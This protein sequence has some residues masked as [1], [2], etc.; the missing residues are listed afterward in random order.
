MKGGIEKRLLIHAGEGGNV[1][2]FLLFFMLVSAGMAIGRSSADALFLKRLGIEYLPIMYMVQSLML[3]A[4]SLVYTAF[5]DRIPAER[6][7]RSLFGILI[8]MILGS[9]FVI[10]TSASTLVYPAYYLIYEVSSELL[11]VHATLYLN[12]N[13]TTL[14]AKRLAPLVFAGAQTGTIMGG[15]TLVVAA[16]VIGTAN[17]LLVWCCLLLAGSVTLYVRHQRHGTSTHFR[18]PGKSQHLLQE[19]LVQPADDFPTWLEADRQ[20]RALAER[21]ILKTVSWLM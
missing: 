17:L 1:L 12:Q 3:A 8:I 16:P 15:L 13:M 4:V 14:Q 21:F 11:L 9:W 5:A 20:A 2:Y 6:F 10:Q 18:A 7:F 19:S